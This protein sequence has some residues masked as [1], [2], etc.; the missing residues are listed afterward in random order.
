MKRTTILLEADLLLEVQQLAREQHVTTSQVIQQAV[1]DYVEGLRRSRSYPSGGREESPSV[2]SSG[3]PTDA[4]QPAEE[5]SETPPA[6]DTRE[7]TEALDSGAGRPSWLR[8]VAVAVGGL[9]ALLALVEFARAATQFAGA[10]V[11]LEVVINYV[12]PGI[13]LGVVASASFF[14]AS[15]SRRTGPT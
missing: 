13:L 7:P 11:P 10:A 2:E 5:K 6:E 9:C 15:Q 4:L 3:W 8:L 12:V 1:A 14:I